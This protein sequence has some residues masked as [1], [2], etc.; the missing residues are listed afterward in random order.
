[1]TYYPLIP[2]GPVLNPGG[3][4]M[5]TLDQLQRK[6]VDAS[7]VGGK[8]LFTEREILSG[9]LCFQPPIKSVKVEDVL[10]VIDADII[11]MKIDIEGY[12]CKVYVSI[13]IFENGDIHNKMT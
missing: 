11:I 3:A 6:N 8:S 4:E 1:M 10:K 12:E 2:A 13:K 9:N 5:L 7:Y